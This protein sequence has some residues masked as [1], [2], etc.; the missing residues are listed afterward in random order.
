MENKEIV[1]EC[2]W[3]VLKLIQPIADEN[4]FGKKWEQMIRYKNIEKIHAARDEA[5][6]MG[7]MGNNTGYSI[8]NACRIA[9]SYAASAVYESTVIKN[10][11]KAMFH[12]EHSARYAK[13]ASMLEHNNRIKLIN[14]II[15]EAKKEIKNE[16]LD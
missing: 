14:E 7:G 2:I 13:S 4:G 9:A 3:D 12:A 5:E 1:F 6:R 11:G 15:S 16:A 8:I 10:N